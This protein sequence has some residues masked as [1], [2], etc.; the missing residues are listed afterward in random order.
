[1]PP[2]LLALQNPSSKAVELLIEQYAFAEYARSLNIRA[3]KDEVSRVLN[4]YQ[5]FK[6]EVTGKFSA[7]KLRLFLKRSGVSQ[8]SFLNNI[9]DD[10][11][12]EITYNALR[13]DV[14]IPSYMTKLVAEYQGEKREI[15]FAYIDASHFKTLPTLPNNEE[16]QKKFF[17]N[18]KTDSNFIVPE[19]RDLEYV[20]FSPNTL[21]DIVP[22]KDILKA[23]YTKHID[24]YKTQEERKILQLFFETEEAGKEALA[25]LEKGK[26]FIPSAMDLGFEMENMDLGTI[27]R[28]SLDQNITDQIF[29][30][31]EGEFTQP[32][33]NGFGYVI[34]FSEEVSPAEVRPFESVAGAIKEEL[35]Q[36]AF[37]KFAD[38][39]SDSLE[40][41]I[42]GGMTLAE[43]AEKYNAPL[44]SYKNITISGADYTTKQIPIKNRKLLDS[45]FEAS[46]DDEALYVSLDNGGFIYGNVKNIASKRIMSFEEAKPLLP[47]LLSL[48]LLK[49]KWQN[50]QQ[51]LP[52]ILRRLF[53]LMILLK[54]II[55][56]C[57][58]KFLKDGNLFLKFQDFSY[59]S[60]LMQIK[61]V[62]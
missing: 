49:Q 12:R 29:A 36:D 56:N 37:R 40:D 7:E 19:T 34:Y 52:R 10:I 16:E 60:F 13:S 55:L 45:F 43:I 27:T 5:F 46:L 61:T 24:R 6:D 25:K 38:S 18:N 30:V 1:M 41:D 11:L 2:E 62:F 3:P 14:H 48:N 33:S 39:N 26:D 57:K 22:S 8:E 17:E 59:L 53:L 28:A 4:Q 47:E 15:S 20:V 50:Y 23:H 42:A 21:T 31:K 32:I 51:R 58:V 54:N 44:A 35:L 9:E